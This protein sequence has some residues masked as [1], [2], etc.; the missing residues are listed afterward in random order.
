M[1]LGHGPWLNGSLPPHLHRAR[2]MH[3]RLADDLTAP[4]TCDGYV[5][6]DCDVHVD[7]ERQGEREDRGAT[8]DC[9]MC[10]HTHGHL[11]VGI[12]KQ[13]NRWVRL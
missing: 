2:R 7:Q 9:G 3:V 5:A 13:M 4:G 8:A 11:Y 6:S 10:R 1:A 12:W